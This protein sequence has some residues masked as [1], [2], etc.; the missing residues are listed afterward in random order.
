MIIVPKEL[1]VGLQIRPKSGNVESADGGR[2]VAL[3]LATYKNAEG[4]IQHEEQFNKW[5]DQDIPR[6]AYDN[7]P[8]TGYS[9]AGSVSRYSTSNK[10]IRA[11]DPRGWQIEIPV[12]NFIQL[13]RDCV[14]DRGVIQDE[15]ILGWD[16]GVRLYKYGSDDHNIGVDNFEAK[17]LKTISIKDVKLGYLI[18]LN[19]GKTG[20][21]MGAWHVVTEQSWSDETFRQIFLLNRT[22]VISERVFFMEIDGY[23]C[24]SKSLTAKRILAEE[25]WTEGEVL[26]RLE[27]RAAETIKFKH[28]KMQAQAEISRQGLIGYNDR[29]KAA[30]INTKFGLL[31]DGYNFAGREGYRWGLDDILLVSNKKIDE[32]FVQSVWKK[33]KVLYNGDI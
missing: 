33:F 12:E 21:F 26:N 30:V 6:M 8:V 17:T 29:A 18:R 10:L 20:R 14:I 16:N 1:Y 13:I 23:I 3:G 9:V 22:K 31:E 11:E 19:N 25:V 7:T 24:H 15:L 27:S 28:L 32:D 5:R 4:K 2:N